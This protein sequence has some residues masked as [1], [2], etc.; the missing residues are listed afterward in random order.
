M[1]RESE[2]KKEVADLRDRV[3][4]LEV[5]I[6]ELNKRM[7]ASAKYMKDLYEYLQ[8]QHGRPPY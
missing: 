6:E 7:D 8:R 3:G 4:R 5:Q 1:A 2:L